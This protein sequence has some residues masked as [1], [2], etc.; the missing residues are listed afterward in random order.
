MKFSYVVHTRKKYSQATYFFG[1]EKWGFYISTPNENLVFPWEGNI[2]ENEK[3]IKLP[4]L[5]IIVICNIRS[6]CLIIDFWVETVWDNF[7]KIYNISDKFIVTQT[8]KWF[9]CNYIL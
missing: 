5:I 4:T 1:N 3:K 6:M 8:K 2:L 7:R 9:I